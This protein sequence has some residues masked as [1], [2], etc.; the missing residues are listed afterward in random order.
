VQA[1]LTR[2]VWVILLEMTLLGYDMVNN[3]ERIRLVR[4]GIVIGNTH[5]YLCNS[6]SEGS[7]KVVSQ[8]E[9][10]CPVILG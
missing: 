3:Q 7:N 9:N 5:K 6:L 10:A 1:S 8:Y 2:N 4:Q